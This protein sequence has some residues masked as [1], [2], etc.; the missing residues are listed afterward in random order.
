MVKVTLTFLTRKW[1]SQASWAISSRLTKRMNHSLTAMEK[2]RGEMCREKWLLL[3]KEWPREPFFGIYVFWRHGHTIYPMPC[4]SPHLEAK[5]PASRAWTSRHSHQMKSEKAVFNAFLS[6]P[7]FPGNSRPPQNKCII[8]CD[9]QTGGNGI[10]SLSWATLIWTYLTRQSG[11]CSS[12]ERVP[13]R[14]CTYSFVPHLLNAQCAS[15]VR[16][17]ADTTINKIPKNPCSDWLWKHS[18]F[19]NNIHQQWSLNKWN[20]NKITRK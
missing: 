4:Y 17:P 6:F 7:Q 2:R 8:K 16:G 14:K 9:S 12:P 11:T 19:L 5:L 20:C 1:M 18:P 13:W 15:T 3:L 10:L